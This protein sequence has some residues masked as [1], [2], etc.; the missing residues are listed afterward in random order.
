LGLGFSHRSPRF[1]VLGSPPPG[2]AKRP[3]RVNQ[4]EAE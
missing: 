4:T 3:S 2:V 1:D